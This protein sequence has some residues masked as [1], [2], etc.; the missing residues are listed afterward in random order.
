MNTMIQRLMKAFHSL[1]LGRIFV[2]VIACGTLA[3]SSGC[4]QSDTVSMSGQ[5]TLDRQLLATGDIELIPERNTGGPTVGGVIADGR[6]DLPT[7]RGPRR[8]GRYR[9]EIRSLDPESGST[10]HPLSRGKKVYSDRIP[11]AYNT[12]SQLSISVPENVSHL[13]KDFELQSN[14]QP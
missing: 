8:G 11:A 5:I 13:Q 12:E 14:A 9:V 6:Y 2:F 7:S 10:N 3:V 1:D 4:G